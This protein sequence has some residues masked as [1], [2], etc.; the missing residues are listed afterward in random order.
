MTI[1]ATCDHQFKVTSGNEFTVENATNNLKEQFDA[2]ECREDVS[3]A[4]ARVVYANEK[5]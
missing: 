1:C 3:Q 5:H 2:H 4:T